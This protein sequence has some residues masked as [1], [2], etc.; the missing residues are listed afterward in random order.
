MGLKAILNKVC[1]SKEQSFAGNP[2]S[3][4]QSGGYLKEVTPTEKWNELVK[5]TSLKALLKN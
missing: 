2:A 1:I 5:R 3:P 4:V